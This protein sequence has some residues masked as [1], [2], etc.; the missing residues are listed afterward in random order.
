MPAVVSVRYR[1]SFRMVAHSTPGSRQR[2]VCMVPHIADDLEK[3]ACFVLISRSSPLPLERLEAARMQGEKKERWMELCA[4]AAIE[5]D[6]EKL[7]ALVEEIDRLLQ[8]K[9]DSLGK[10]HPSSNS[11]PPLKTPRP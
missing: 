6:P 9:E 2:F 3:I 8:E 1:T 5:Q 11:V 4:Q 10:P 7:H